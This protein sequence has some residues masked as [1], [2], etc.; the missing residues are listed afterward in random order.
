[1]TDVPYA[2]LYSSI[3]AAAGHHIYEGRWLHNQQYLNDYQTFWL[4]GADKRIQPRQYSF[5]I[6]NAYYACYLV[7]ADQTF[8][9]GLL[10]QLDANYQAWTTPSNYNA[11]TGRYGTGYDADFGLYYQTPVWDAMENSLSSYQD[12]VDAYHGGEGY[13]PTI[14]AYQYGDALAIAQIAQLAGNLG[15]AAKY[16]KQATTLKKTM[17]AKLWNPSLNFFVPYFRSPKVFD[18][19]GLFDGREEIGYIPWYFNL[20]DPQYSVAWRY[21]MDSDH[22][23]TAYG[24]T[25]GDQ[26]YRASISANGFN[27]GMNLFMYQADKPYR[28][29]GPSWPFATSQ[30]LTAM[31]NVLNNQSFY[32]APISADDYY[33]LLRNYALTQYKDGYPY[34]AEAHSPTAATWIYDTPN[35]SE[36]YN[37]STYNDLII[38]GLIGLRPRADN[39]L[40]VSPLVPTQGPNSW[41]YFCLEDVLYHRHLVTILYDQD[42]TR[43]KQGTGFQLFVDGAK[44]WSSPTIQHVRV[45]LSP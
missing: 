41:K 18:G 31:A 30:T 16:A 45:K 17:Q 35:H 11:T 19:H 21:L 2:G 13:R 27:V 32:R 20:P 6:A 43:Y 29:N 15:L 3:N 40:E 42:G 26:S 10:N 23:Y 24:P 33:T 22:F 7:N 4:S 28:W 25:T 39:V 14:N 9:T 37:H 38:T 44:I 1:M 36:H 5:W 8:L 34:V 12:P